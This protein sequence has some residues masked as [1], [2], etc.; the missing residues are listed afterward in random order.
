VE[1]LTYLS[2]VKSDRDLLTNHKVTDPNSLAYLALNRPMEGI[3]LIKPN[4]RAITMPHNI[5]L[6][7]ASGYLGGDL[8]AGLSDANLPP[9][10]TLYALVRTPEQAKAVEQHGAKPLI[11]DV[12]DEASVR[13]AVLENEIT[14]VFFLIDATSAVSQELFIKALGEMKKKTGSDVHFLHVSRILFVGEIRD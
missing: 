5:L 13:D 8:L 1:G 6:T 12:K 11:F 10:G 9:Y 7:G 2:I 3:Y 14:V 4:A